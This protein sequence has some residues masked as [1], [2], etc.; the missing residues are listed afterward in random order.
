MALEKVLGQ[1]RAE[2]LLFG[3][4]ER[5][6]QG[7]YMEVSTA[8]ALKSEVGQVEIMWG[9]NSVCFEIMFMQSTLWNVKFKTNVIDH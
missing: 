4:E 1:K 6:W 8:A 9:P 3:L 2:K 7:N 5:Q